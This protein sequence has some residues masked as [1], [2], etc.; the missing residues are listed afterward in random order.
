MTLLSLFMPIA[1]VILPPPIPAYQPVNDPGI[2]YQPGLGDVCTDIG[3]T[4]AYWACMTGENAACACSNGTECDQSITT[5][6]GQTLTKTGCTKGSFMG[7]G[8]LK[9]FYWNPKTKKNEE[10]IIRC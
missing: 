1:M 7:M 10:R 6:D 8:G 3:D 2:E 9:C 4:D 5:D